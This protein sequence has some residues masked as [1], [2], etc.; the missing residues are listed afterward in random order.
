M[1]VNI[2]P[3][4]GVDGEKDFRKQINQCVQ[5]TKTLDSEMK[6]LTSSFDGNERSQSELAKQSEI[7]TKQVTSQQDKLELLQKGLAESTKKYGESDTRTQKWAQAVYDATAQLN[8][9]TAELD[10]VSGAMTDTADGVGDMETAMDQAADAA[11]D[12]ADSAHDTG[13]S[14]NDLLGASLVSNAISYMADTIK[15]AAEDTKEYRKIMGSLEVSSEKAGYTARQTAETYT[16]LYG[17]LA[18]DQT[19]ATT[20]ANLQAL[21]LSQDELRKAT[22][23]TIGAWATYGDSI[24]IDG[25]AEAINETAKTGTVTGTFADVL[26]WAGESEDGFNEELQSTSDTSERTRKILTVMT[27]QGLEKAGQAWQSNNKTLVESNKATAR[28]QGALAKLGATIEPLLT[29]VTG[30]TTNLFE[31]IAD[32]GKTVITVVSGIGA[33][34]AAWKVTNALDTVSASWGKL[35]TAVTTANPV[36]IAAAGVTG[37]VAA[38]VVAGKEFGGVSDQISAEMDAITEAGQAMKETADGFDDAMSGL[39]STSKKM[40]ASGVYAENLGSR[41]TELADKT[42][43]TST[44]QAEMGQIVEKLNSLFPDLGL[45]INDTTGELNMST[46]AI[47]AY[48]S[49]ASEMAKMEKIQEH[50][51]DAVGEVTEMEIARAEAEI[52]AQDAADKLTDLDTQREKILKKVNAALGDGADAAGVYNSTMVE[53]NGKIMSAADALERLNSDA[54]DLRDSQNELNSQIDAQDEKIASANEQLAV[55]DQVMQ[56]VTGTTRNSAAAYNEQGAAATS[57]ATSADLSAA[58]FSAL[59]GAQA[60]YTAGAQ[61]L[62]AQMEQSIADSLQSQMTMFE[63]F[64][65]GV[66]LST[67]ELLNNMQSQIDGVTNWESNLAIL[68]DRGIN[69]ELLKYLIDMGPK[70]A[71]YVKTFANMTESEFQRANSLWKQGLDVQGMAN[72]TGQDLISALGGNVS[73][74]M[75]SVSATGYNAAYNSG[76]N[77][78]AGMRDGVASGAASVANAVTQIAL[79]A[80]NAGN[81]TLGIHSPSKVFEQIGA[82]TAEGFVVGLDKTTDTVNEAVASL[83]TFGN[84]YDSPSGGGYPAAASVITAGAGI[85]ITVNAAPGQSEDAIANK[86]MYKLQHD[87]SKAGAVW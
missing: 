37:L 55:Y 56:S 46:D 85:S 42:N 66:E 67:D 27:K 38:A 87:V 33:A 16:T 82:Y 14:F 59:Q 71:N 9:M 40:E 17:V 45:T 57:A 64:N 68:A 1:A 15:N 69:Q 32:N 6:A 4:I 13:I 8:R 21:G 3:V 31:F 12:L 2:G 26:N 76:K 11:D 24:P 80:V 20:A 86:V 39:E 18:D 70:G 28:Q 23:A 36:A 63:E 81:K 75:S 62:V 44:E 30:L 22:N 79:S 29:D 19:A 78:S 65:G 74:A 48:I 7:L 84:L 34:F 50:Y 51:A 77:I 10:D 43:R 61:A 54:Q 47:E 72:Q 52:A 25:L 53:Y 58:S 5:V 41:L 35:V 73:S 60:A 49:K 83:F